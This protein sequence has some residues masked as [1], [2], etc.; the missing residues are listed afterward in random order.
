M[1][2]KALTLLFLF[3]GAIIFSS[4][5]KYEEGGPLFSKKGTLTAEWEFD[6]YEAYNDNDD[7]QSVNHSDYEETLI[8]EKDGTY[9][10]E[11][12]YGNNSYDYEGKWEFFDDKKYIRVIYEGDNYS[13]GFT[14]RIYKLKND[15]LIFEEWDGD[16]ITYTAK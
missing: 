8:F 3:G 1:K 14:W 9:E 6:D 7:H 2:K 13:S 10:R 16:L 15:E 5:S 12:E 4:C 11:I